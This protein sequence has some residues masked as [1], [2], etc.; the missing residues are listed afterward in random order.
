[1]AF[2]Y[3]VSLRKNPLKPLLDPQA[4]AKAQASKVCEF[5]TVCNRIADRSSATAGDV[6]LVLDG[7]F[8][9]VAESVREGEIVVLG[10]FGRFQGQISGSGA[11]TIK[12]YH[13]SLIRKIR[14]QFKPCKALTASF[15]PES[16]TFKQVAKKVSLKPSGQPAEKPAAE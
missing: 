8:S 10:D 11:D 1:M 5:N 2:T 3:S 12:E 9:V 13:P 16:V 4:Y 6:K 14:L 15:L 7:L